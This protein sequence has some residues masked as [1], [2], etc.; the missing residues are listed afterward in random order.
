MTSFLNM[1]AHTTTPLFHFKIN[2]VPSVNAQQNKAMMV[3]LSFFIS[4]IFPFI[5]HLSSTISTMKI[6]SISPKQVIKAVDP[7]NLTSC[8]LAVLK[9]KKKDH[10]MFYPIPGN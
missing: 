8:N 7:T 10:L 4:I 6:N 5:I 2:C 3:L 9:K 1:T